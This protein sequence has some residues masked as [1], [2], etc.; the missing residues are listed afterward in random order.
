MDMATAL[1]GLGVTGASLDTIISK[2]L[3]RDGYAPLPA[4][5]MGQQLETMRARLAELT[6]AEGE[7]GSATR[8]GCSTISPWP[9]A[10][11][12]WCPAPTGSV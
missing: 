2:R 4:V 11:P 10:Q 1:A 7:A 8:S 12:E 6:A 3:D 9:T 5:L